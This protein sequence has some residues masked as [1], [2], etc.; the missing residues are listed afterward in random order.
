MSLAAPHADSRLC[1]S[2]RSSCAASPSSSS[3]WGTSSPPS[4]SSTRSCRTRTKTQSGIEGGQRGA[5]T[6]SPHQLHLPSPSPRCR[7]DS[8]V[9]PRSLEACG[10]GTELGASSQIDCVFTAALDPSH[11]P[12]GRSALQPLSRLPSSGE[13][14]A[15]RAAPLLFALRTFTGMVLL[16]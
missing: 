3:S 2:H 9:S 7:P 4:V 16:G 1:G 15:W 14:A 13:Q 10:C 5:R 11:S 12:G 8:G 6:V